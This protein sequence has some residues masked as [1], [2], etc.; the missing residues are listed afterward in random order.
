MITIRF[1]YYNYIELSKHVEHS[2]TFSPTNDSNSNRYLKCVNTLGSIV[3]SI[4]YQ[5]I[6]AWFSID[7][8][9]LT[10]WDYSHFCLLFNQTS[11][12]W[13]NG[14]DEKAARGLQ[15]RTEC[16]WKRGVNKRVNDNVVKHTPTEKESKMNR[17]RRVGS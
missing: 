13:V 7:M 3:M 16:T 5:V 12:Q 11:S 17:W 6:W 10:L 1:H 4:Y 9:C 8:V 2:L 14:P 15:R